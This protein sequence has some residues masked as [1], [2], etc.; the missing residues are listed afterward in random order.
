[1][2][3]MIC[4][5]DGSATRSTRR[6]LARTYS[7]TPSTDATATGAAAGAGAAGCACAGAGFAAGAGG[8]AVG[9]AGCAV[10]ADLHATSDAR[11]RT[12]GDVFMGDL[13]FISRFWPERALD[14]SRPGTSR[15]GARRTAAG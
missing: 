14:R 7:D 6:P 2:S 10:D 4:D 15:R 3:V 5:C 8:A 11:A 9:A 1:M 12:M 13:P